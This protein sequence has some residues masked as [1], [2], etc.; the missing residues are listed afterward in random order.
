MNPA[1]HVEGDQSAYVGTENVARDYASPKIGGYENGYVKYDMA[2]GFGNE[3][4]QY[5]FPY[6]TTSGG[7]GFEWQIPLNMIDRFN[8]LTVNRTWIKW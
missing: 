1:S 6:V 3:F 5:R 8:E 7:A 2:Q 4:A